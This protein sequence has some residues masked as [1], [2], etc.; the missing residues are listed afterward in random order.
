M[1]A[2]SV[3]VRREGGTVETITGTYVVLTT[4]STYPAPMKV[5]Q[6]FEAAAPAGCLPTHLHSPGVVQGDGPSRAA[7]V[8]SF[9]RVQAAL[10][11]ATD[12][13]VVG[14]GPT[15]VEAAGAPRREW[16]RSGAPPLG[17]PSSLPPPCGAAC[18]R[19][20]G[21]PAP[22]QRDARA[23]GRD[24]P[25]GR[26]ERH[27][28]ARQVRRAP[29]DPVDQARLRAPPA[30]RPP[31]PLPCQ[32]QVPPGDCGQACHA[33]CRCQ[34][35]HARGPARGARADR[36]L[37]ADADDHPDD[38]CG[39]RLRDPPRRRD[40]LLHGRL[41]SD[42]RHSSVL[43]CRC[44]RAGELARPGLDSRNRR[45]ISAPILSA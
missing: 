42:R 36:G 41:P 32:R 4:G 1:S 30:S 3:T 17:S 27:Q 14:G 19:D 11:A 31:P 2:S 5:Q 16:R 9:Q 28:R 18:R 39:R 22:R 40:V 13:V 12:V 33:R 43:P 45:A 6:G 23:L 21:S 25:R 34:V 20:Q 15:A 7:V 26:T 29:C 37:A 35:E 44:G 24:A 8:Q 38:D 10:A